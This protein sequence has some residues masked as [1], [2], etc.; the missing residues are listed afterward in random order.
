MEVRA[1]VKRWFCRKETGK[2]L[3]LI[4]ILKK[5]L[6][7]L[8]LKFFPS[9]PLLNLTLSNGLGLYLSRK[10]IGT[11]IELLESLGISLVL[12]LLIAL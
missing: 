4:R 7:S 1:F 10:V 6:L 2:L 3:F 5:R 11:P 8:I 12:S 9:S